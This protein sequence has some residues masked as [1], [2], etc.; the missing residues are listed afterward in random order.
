MIGVLLSL[1]IGG[2]LQRYLPC[3][4]G[5]TVTYADAAGR[6]VDEEVLGFGVAAEPRV[7]AIERRLGAGRER[8]GREYLADRVTNAGWLDTPLALRA[9]ILK[10]PLSVGARWHWNREDHQVT[11]LGRVVEVPAGRF[12]DTVWI[13]SRSSDG[14][15]AATAVYAAGVGLVLYQSAGRQLSATRVRV[16]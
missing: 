7:C 5:L 15:H 8:L 2:G 10:A 1:M 12:A 13:T 6:E 11:A 3:T 9:P 16:P 4:P 14:Q